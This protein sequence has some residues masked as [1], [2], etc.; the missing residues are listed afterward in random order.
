MYIIA[1]TLALGCGIGCGSLISPVLSSYII[2]KNLNLKSGLSSLLVFSLGKIISMVLLG[3]LVSIFATNFIDIDS[4][5]YGIPFSNFFSLFIAI[6]G[7]KII[8]D[9]IKRNKKKDCVS[10][11]K[12]DK[13]DPL[14]IYKHD[15]NIKTSYL[16]IWDYCLLFLSGAAYGITPC[17]PLV[18]LLVYC[19]DLSVLQ[20]VS[21]MS[22][23]GIVSIISPAIISTIFATLINKG[24][25]KDF[26]GMNLELRFLSGILLLLVG[27][28][29]II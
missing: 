11:K 12:C 26:K 24:I 15:K 22:L 27:I 3:I 21:L 13:I 20:A 29:Y 2:G 16:Q 8:Y 17:V 9:V 5:F 4:S 7:V 19:V 23:F 14:T 25:S 6:L 18:S 10:S 1:I 28:F